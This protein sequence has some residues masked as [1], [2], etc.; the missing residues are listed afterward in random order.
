MFVMYRNRT[1]VASLK[2]IGAVLL[3]AVSFMGGAEAA[4]AKQQP[5]LTEE[6]VAII[7][8]EALKMQ[9]LMWQGFAIPYSIERRSQHKDAA[10]LDILFNHQLL[11]REKETRVIEIK[12]SNR[13]RIALNYRYSFANQPDAGST[14]SQLGFYYGYGRL[15]NILELSK[16]YLIGDAYYAEVYVQWYVADIQSWVDAP[17]FD[18]ART[19]RRS[20]ESKEKPFEKRV[21]L[22]YNGHEWAFWN[23]KPGGL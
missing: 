12:G 23:G 9:P 20:L 6:Q 18:H 7:I 21:Y 1:T 2:Q 13:K 22:Q 8:D 19:L 14:S 3:L 16:P 15:K 4:L 17:A 5:S 10:M 11:V